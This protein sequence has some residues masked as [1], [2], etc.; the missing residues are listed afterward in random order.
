[1]KTKFLTTA[2]AA[3]FATATF[4]MTIDTASARS[5]HRTSWAQGSGGRGYVKNVDRNCGGGTCT[6]HR[7]VQTNGGYAY[8]ADHSR[9]CANG[10]C[11]GSTTVTGNN[12]RSWT[13]NSGY[14]NGGD[15]S[16]SWYSNTTGPNGGSI[17]RS[18][19]ATGPQ[20]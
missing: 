19:S 4:A 8:T 12:G 20:Y 13:H 7:S 3:V 11:N 15:G 9:S 10:S 18:G 6:G 5:F 16:A 1:M 14:T 17:S 2:L